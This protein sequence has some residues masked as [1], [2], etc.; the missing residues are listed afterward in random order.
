MT[1]G[2]ARS[3]SLASVCVHAA[4][5]HHVPSRGVRTRPP[6]TASGGVLPTATYRNMSHPLLVRMSWEPT[7]PVLPP[8]EEQTS[9]PGLGK[10]P[11]RGIVAQPNWSSGPSAR[12]LEGSGV[13]SARRDLNMS[14]PDRL[15]GAYLGVHHSLVGSGL[16]SGA[17]I[18]AP[19]R[20]GACQT[21]RGRWN[22]PRRRLGRVTARH[23]MESSDGRGPPRLPDDRARDSASLDPVRKRFGSRG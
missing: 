1:T 22:G 15:K 20:K 2:E 21:I 13:M 3:Q 5:L 12:G 6:A 19:I 9:K 11:R 23:R 8:K 7:R 17:D 4:S 10:L 16:L 14:G 18:K